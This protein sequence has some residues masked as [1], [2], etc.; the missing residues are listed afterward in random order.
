MSS[1]NSRGVTVSSILQYCVSRYMRHDV[2]MDN[3]STGRKSFLAAVKHLPSSFAPCSLSRSNSRVKVADA[4][5]G[6]GDPS[7]RIH[8]I[9]D[10][11]SSF[12]SDT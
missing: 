5:S 11:P 8:E 3:G 2:V 4:G 12:K 6:E 7:D 1:T 10:A 9:A